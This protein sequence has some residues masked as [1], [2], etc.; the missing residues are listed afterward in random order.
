MNQDY[1]VELIIKAL[2]IIEKGIEENC[3][4]SEIKRSIMIL[5]VGHWDECM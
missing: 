3:D 4:G 2:G 5:V 1:T